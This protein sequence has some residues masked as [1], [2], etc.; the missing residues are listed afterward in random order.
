[1]ILEHAVATLFE[2]SDVSPRKIDEAP[3]KRA[4]TEYLRKKAARQEQHRT[5][6]SGSGVAAVSDG[7][8]VLLVIRSVRCVMAKLWASL[9]GQMAHGPLA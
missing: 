6:M 2:A 4:R 1:M 3:L 9:Q 7:S 5:G 8:T